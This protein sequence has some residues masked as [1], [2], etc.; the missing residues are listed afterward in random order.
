MA[1][2]LDIFALF[3]QFK[4][5]HRAEV[6][7]FESIMQRIIKTYRSSTINYNIN[8]VDDHVSVGLRHTDSLL[9]QV[10]FNWD[11]SFSC[12]LPEVIFAHLFF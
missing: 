12:H 3:T 9:Y 7:N 1:I 2:G 8:V 5:P 11:N 4:H 10:A 6:V